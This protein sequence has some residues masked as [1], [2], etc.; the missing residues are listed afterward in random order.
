MTDVELVFDPPPPRSRRSEHLPF[1]LALRAAPA[2]DLTPEGPATPYA[3]VKVDLGEKE[4]HS[5]ASTIRAAARSIGEGFDIIARFIPATNA[6]GVWARYVHV[7]ADAVPTPE[8]R[9][10]A[11]AMIADAM[12]TRTAPATGSVMIPV[13]STETLIGDGSGQ[14][15]PPADDDLDP[16]GEDDMDWELPERSGAKT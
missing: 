2:T 15:L 8:A 13:P 4:A 1:L 12:N 16:I 14:A 9:E 6:Y 10:E 11:K 5:L 7:T 3:R